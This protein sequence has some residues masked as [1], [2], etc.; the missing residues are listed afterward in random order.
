MSS[1]FYSAFLEAGHWSGN[2]IRFP[3]SARP[4]A[5]RHIGEMET[6]RSCVL[7]SATGDL[8][9]VGSLRNPGPL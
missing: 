9:L 8:R 5:A 2:G 6:S 1:S 4:H 7:A 3:L